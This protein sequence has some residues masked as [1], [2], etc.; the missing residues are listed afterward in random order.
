MLIIKKGQEEII[1]ALLTVDNPSLPVNLFISLIDGVQLLA[2]GDPLHVTGFFE[3]DTAED[4]TVPAD[5]K[6]NIFPK[7]N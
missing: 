6:L 5:L 2:V 1:A 7:H 3:P 4:I